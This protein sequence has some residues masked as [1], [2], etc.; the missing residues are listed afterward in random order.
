MSIPRNNSLVY[1][2]YE[3]LPKGYDKKLYPFKK[4]HVYIFL[5]EIPNLPGYCTV[6]DSTTNEIYVNY[7]V[8][9]K[10]YVKGA[11]PI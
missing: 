9:F 6:I 8:Y 4:N 11:A 5:G 2:D 10:E 3:S 1:F 7:T